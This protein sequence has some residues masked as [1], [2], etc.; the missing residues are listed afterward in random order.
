MV[1]FSDYFDVEREDAII[2]LTAQG[3]RTGVHNIIVV[4]RTGGAS[5]PNMIKSNIPARTV[6][7]LTSAGESRAID[8]SG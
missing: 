6:F 4:D 3:A 7:R 2:R 8:V 1:S 5:L